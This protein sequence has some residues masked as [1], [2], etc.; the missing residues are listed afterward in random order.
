MRTEIANILR[1]SSQAIMKITIRERSS[2]LA[3]NQ[4]FL[5]SVDK[6]K[7]FNANDKQTV[8][9]VLARN[10]ESGK[11][12]RGSAADL[13]QAFP[14]M[15]RK[16]AEAIARTGHTEMNNLAQ[17]EKYR[18]K[19]FQSFTIDS[20]AEACD[21][22]NETYQGYVFSIDDT[23]MLPP[24]HPHCY[25][26]ETEVFTKE[27]W[28]LF[29]DVEDNDL[30][31]SMDPETH[32]TE[33]IP[34]IQSIGYHYQ[35]ELYHIHNRWFD[36]KVTPD[37]DVYAEK[38]VDHGKAGRKLE[39]FFVKP[40]DLHSEHRI[41]RTCEHTK[42]S[43]NHIMVGGVK[44]KPEDYAYFMAWWISEGCTISTRPP[45]IAISQYKD[46]I[47]KI[48]RNIKRMIPDSNVYLN[49]NNIEFRHEGLYKYLLDLGKSGEKYIP[50]ELFQLS[51]DHLN[52]FLDNYVLGDGHAR[53][54]NNNLVQNSTERVLFTSSKRLAGDLS[55]IILLAGY[56]PSLSVEKT[57]GREVK[58][59]NGTYTINNNL[60]RIS[61]NKTRHTNIS[62]CK[63]DLIPYDGFVYCLELP[64][65][66][67]LWIKSNNKTGW[68]GNCMCVAVYHEESPE[69]Y[70]EKNGLEVYGGG[71]A[72]E[73]PLTDITNYLDDQAL[74]FIEDFIETRKDAGIEFGHAFDSKTGI[75]I[76]GEL[77]G[78]KST[79]KGLSGSRV[80]GFV[81]NGADSIIH[82]HPPGRN[83]SAPS[84]SD[85]NSA[86]GS[87]T[88]NDVIVSERGNY[89]IRTDGTP[90]N[91]FR[92][93]LEL[94]AESIKAQRSVLDE[95]EK[96]ALKFNSDKDLLDVVNARYEEALFRRAGEYGIKII[97]W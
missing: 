34:F 87:K 20:T 80:D 67:T 8:R 37:H 40:G 90:V 54:C 5:K 88:I 21:E 58:F 97:K 6:I 72:E 95:I 11:G 63:I 12:M 49:G 29:K 36:M 71:E 48:H 10:L 39:P 61:I 16:R 78:G 14:D 86:L 3:R 15:D 46:N 9:E 18:E 47:H 7:G 59:E 55:Y 44:F 77:K 64:K 31:L 73:I 68:G 53:K 30:I 76:S 65:W 38:R 41:P 28:K 85:V 52:I 66:H 91:G 62:N 35:G 26:D 57:K 27:G 89:L 75:S 69:E 33:F 22:C 50:K 79:I 70:A 24:L 92:I 13:R 25:D 1:E 60:N 42:E 17:N 43:P 4:D 94:R 81:K 45:V 82:N 23:D 93:E 32:Q 83:L 74:Q 56:Y 84:P 19:G 51:R 2:L 96:G